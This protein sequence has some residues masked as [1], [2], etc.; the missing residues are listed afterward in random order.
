M[1]INTTARIARA[2]A[3]FQIA[4]RIAAG[5]Q[6]EADAYARE[7]FAA[8]EHKI[9]PDLIR[10]EA[11]RQAYIR[12]VAEGALGCSIKIVNDGRAHYRDEH[13]LIVCTLAADASAGAFGYY[14][15]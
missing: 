3:D 10:T 13:G 12:L 11:Q 8:N 4:H 9:D 6:P 15:W 1:T 7:H 14:R 5:G 2:E